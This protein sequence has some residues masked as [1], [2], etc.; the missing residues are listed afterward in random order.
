MRISSYF[1]TFTLVSAFNQTEN[2]LKN[3]EFPIGIS[4]IDENN[5]EVINYKALESVFLHPKVESR[6][7]FVLTVTGPAKM[8]KSFLLDYCLRFLYANV[9]KNF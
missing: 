3:R 4:W 9:S 7:I 1:F 8:G 2:L 5:T 6:K